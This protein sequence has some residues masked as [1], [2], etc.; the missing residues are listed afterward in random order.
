MTV[1]ETT[2]VR[3]ETSILEAEFE[4]DDMRGEDLGFLRECL[5][6]AGALDVS[7]TPVMMKKDRPGHRVGVLFEA[8]RESAVEEAIFRRSSTF[9]FRLR[10]AD[11]RVLDREIVEVLTEHGPCRVKVGRHR[12]EIVQVRP[13]YEDVAKLARATGKQLHE[14]EAAAVAAFSRDKR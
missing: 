12:G 6:G 11:R 5:V 7:F 3:A 9:G 10:R 14:I 2:A 8:A 1:A 13:E 4:V